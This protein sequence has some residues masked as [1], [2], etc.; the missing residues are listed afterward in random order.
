MG[1]SGSDIRPILEAMDHTDLMEFSEVL[2]KRVR[3]GMATLEDFGQLARVH[4]ELSRR[5]SGGAV[6]LRL[7]T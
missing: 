4:E 3:A 2:D 7:D 6:G 5:T 1:S